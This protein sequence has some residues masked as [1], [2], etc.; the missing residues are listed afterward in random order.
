MYRDI[1]TLRVRWFKIGWWTNLALI[2]VYFVAITIEI[3]LQCLPQSV[4]TLWDSK[5]S[6]LSVAT[7]TNGVWDPK[8]CSGLDAFAI[9]STNGMG[10]SHAS[11]AEDRRFRYLPTRIDARS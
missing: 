10:S 11:K 9:T 2:I 1:F 4:D 6:L 7:T 8:C 5:T 3:C